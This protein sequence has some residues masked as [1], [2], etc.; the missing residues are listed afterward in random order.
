VG[1]HPKQKTGWNNR[2]SPELQAK[3]RFKAGFAMVGD[4]SDSTMK[5]PQSHAWTF[6][7]A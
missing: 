4:D 3:W 5:L 1:W 2:N 7:P 6:G